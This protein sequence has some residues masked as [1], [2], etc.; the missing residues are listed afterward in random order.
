MTGSPNPFQ[1]LE[2]DLHAAAGRAVARR[3]RHRRRLRVAGTTAAAALVFSAVAVASGI[4][5]ELQ[6]DP[7]KW[8]ILGGGT[9]DGGQGQYVH[10]QNREDGKNSTFMVEHDQGLDR[11]EAFLLHQRLR[12][13]AATSSPVPVRPEKGALCTRAELTR[14]ELA[15]L[16]VLRESFAPGTASDA[17]KQAVDDAVAA[18]FAASPCAGLEYAGERARFVYAG[19]EPTSMLMPGAR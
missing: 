4:G 13:A 19:I 15:A 18:A 8:S 7:T 16:V 12:E 2:R 3:R 10:A 1:L 9:V 17:T 11:Y 6:L 5:P 14:A